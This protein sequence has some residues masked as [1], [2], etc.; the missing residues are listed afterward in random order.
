LFTDLVFVSRVERYLAYFRIVCPV[1]ADVT[2]GHLD[3]FE[4]SRFGSIA[5]TFPVIVNSYRLVQQI[6]IEQGIDSH[7][8]WSET[9]RF[10]LKDGI[11][12]HRIPFFEIS[13]FV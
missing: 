13:S 12:L 6:F 4:K 1:F 10:D 11:R 3:A 9:S 5:V 7:R 8:N 2:D